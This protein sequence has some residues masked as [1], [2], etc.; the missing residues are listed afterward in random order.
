MKNPNYLLVLSAL[1]TLA[2]STGS[3]GG[4]NLEITGGGLFILDADDFEQSHIIFNIK[5]KGSKV[6][7]GAVFNSPTGTDGEDIIKLGTARFIGVK[8]NVDCVT[9][10]EESIDGVDPYKDVL[11]SG[12]IEDGLGV[13]NYSEMKGTTDLTA[14]EWFGILRFYENGLVQRQDWLTEFETCVGDNGPLLSNLPVPGFEPYI[15]IFDPLTQDAFNDCAGSYRFVR[16]S[17]PRCDEVYYSDL[18]VSMDRT[19]DTTVSVNSDANIMLTEK[20]KGKKKK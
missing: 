4:E 2:F 17:F 1:T 18:A 13:Y 16:K 19:V 9:I 11:M 6:T 5:K 14:N 12:T 10:A 3:F 7:G 20:G 8:Y 15:S